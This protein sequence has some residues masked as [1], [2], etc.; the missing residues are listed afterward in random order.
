MQAKSL[1]CGHLKPG[2]KAHVLR[3]IFGVAAA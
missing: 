1:H 2:E 3:E